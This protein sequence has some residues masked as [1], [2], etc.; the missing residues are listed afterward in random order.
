[1][2]RTSRCEEE[3]RAT[4]L[5]GQGRC[6]SGWNEARATKTEWKIGGGNAKGE[7]WGGSFGGRDRVLFHSRLPPHFARR[8]SSIGRS[9]IL[10]IMTPKQPPYACKWADCSSLADTVP[11]LLRHLRLHHLETPDEDPVERFTLGELSWLD[12]AWYAR[13]DD[14][15]PSQGLGQSSSPS[16][17][18]KLPSA[19]PS[20]SRLHMVLMLHQPCTL[21][22]SPGSLIAHKRAQHASHSSDASSSAPSS[23]F[24]SS[25]THPSQLAA[26]SQ[27]RSS[28][29]AAEPL[30]GPP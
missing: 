5:E 7:K 30:A 13:G 10:R 15:V 27:S 8:L 2:A 23:S 16:P 21:C 11:E 18:L 25:Q 6:L 29:R 1:M 3:E 22:P 4:G 24:A 19:R 28:T 9:S 17:L 14:L 26:P 20:R 12:G